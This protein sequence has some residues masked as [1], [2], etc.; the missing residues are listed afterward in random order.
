MTNYYEILG[1]EE[2][3]GKD[4][5]KSAFRKKARELHPDVNKAPHAE[6]QFKELGK[7]YE[8]LMDDEKRAM[9]DRY[10]EEGL[11]NA[12]YA[13]SGPFDFGFGNIND[14]FE[15][16]FGGFGGFGHT[17]DPSAPQRGSDLRLDIELEFKEAAFGVEKEI[18]VSHLEHCEVCS[19]SGAEPGTRP[20]VCTT[21]GGS[22]QIRQVQQTILGQFAQVSAC[23]ACHGKGQVVSS[24]CKACKGKG[25]KEVEKKITIKI[26]A[27]VD[28]GSKIRI[29]NEG[30][31][32]AN[33]GRSGDLYVVLYVKNLKNFKRDGYNVYSELEISVPQA[34]LGDKVPVETLEGLYELNIPQGV[35]SGAVQVIKGQGIPYLNSPSHRGDHFVIIKVLTPK[36][37]SSEEKQIYAKLYELAMNKKH[38]ESFVDKVKNVIGS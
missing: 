7:A 17:H 8:T 6:E 23:T 3:A 1:V 11:K 28:N 26:P 38:T 27:G 33:Q 18:S 4:E 31:A 14:I 32:G 36:K 19:G 22:G 34:V 2:N 9:Y 24:P 13:N 5:I 12:G 25:V 30:D 15:S 20:T 21:C 29:A 10:G 37:L 16:F 35:E